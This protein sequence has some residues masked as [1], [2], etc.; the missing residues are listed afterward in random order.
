MNKLMKYVLAYRA[1][2]ITRRIDAMRL[3][4]QILFDKLYR[5]EKR[6]M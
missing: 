1:N 3:R 6:G 5:I 2:R 4:Q